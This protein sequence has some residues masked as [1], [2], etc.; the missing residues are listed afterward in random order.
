MRAPMREA[1]PGTV[2]PARCNGGVPKYG[3]R[4][5]T[6]H[7]KK[8]P[9]INPIMIRIPPIARL[10]PEPKYA[11]KIPARKLATAKTNINI[12]N[13]KCHQ[14]QHPIGIIFSSSQI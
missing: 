12:L 5:Y 4:I 13:R 11:V 3:S 10:F 7:K 14:L 8:M 6:H 2:V 9:T 1:T